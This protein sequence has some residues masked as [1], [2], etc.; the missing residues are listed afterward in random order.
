MHLQLATYCIVILFRYS[1]YLSGLLFCCCYGSTINNSN[2]K[3]WL[4]IIQKK[5]AKPLRDWTRD[6]AADADF[7]LL[8]PTQPSSTRPT[9]PS[10]TRPT[11]AQVVNWN[12]ADANFFF[13]K[14]GAATQLHSAHTSQSCQLK[15]THKTK[16]WRRQRGSN[17]GLWSRLHSDLPLGY[18]HCC[19]YFRILNILYI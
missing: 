1:V 4:L 5:V 11:P 15:C 17:L 3:C 13:H 6:L 14:A 18:E 10:S 16:K 9:Q 8:K 12:L 2:N 19:V 7:F